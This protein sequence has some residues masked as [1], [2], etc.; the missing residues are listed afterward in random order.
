MTNHAS[1]AGRFLFWYTLSVNTH[2]IRYVRLDT[3]GTIFVL[4]NEPTTAKR[5]INM[6]V[7]VSTKVMHSFQNALTA[8][9]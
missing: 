2:V 6:A 8:P 1:Y 3:P 7:M 9:M 5:L 4:P